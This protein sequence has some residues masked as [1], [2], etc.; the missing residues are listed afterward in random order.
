MKTLHCGTHFD[1]S[2][3]EEGYVDPQLP[4]MKSDYTLLPIG[5]RIGQSEIK[6]CPLCEKA[7]LAKQ[8]DDV[9]F[10]IHAE[11]AGVTQDGFPEIGDETCRV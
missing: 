5:T 6:T 9:L 2:N 11:W 4:P 10:F 7:G 3:V 8:I 1:S